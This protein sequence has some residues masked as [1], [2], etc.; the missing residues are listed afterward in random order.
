MLSG[1][2]TLMLTSARTASHHPPPALAF[3]SRYWCIIPIA[4]NDLGGGKP[5]VYMRRATSAMTRRVLFNRGADECGRDGLGQPSRFVAPKERE[6]AAPCPR[7]VYTKNHHV[8]PMARANLHGSLLV[9]RKMNSLAPH[10][11]RHA[12]NRKWFGIVMDVPAARLGL[13][14]NN[15]ADVLNVKVD[16]SEAAALRLADGILPA[17]HMNKEH[18]VSVLLGGRVSD[19]MLIELLETSYRLTS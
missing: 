19:E 18:W 11:L 17:Y 12:G 7:R 10:V 9:G 13:E 8:A 5:Y 4:K 15:K 2:S 14:G 1:H 16:P 3:P 6:A